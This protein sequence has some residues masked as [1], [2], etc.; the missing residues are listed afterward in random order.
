MIYYL[1]EDSLDPNPTG[2]SVIDPGPEGFVHCCDERQIHEVLKAYFP[3]DARVLAVVVDP[4]R[5]SSET[6]YEPGSGGEAERFAHVYGP[7]QRSAVVE[8]IA[9]K[10]DG[11]N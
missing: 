7:I 1:A 6:R 10:A 3:S 9:L 5:L 4:T 2:D 11:V 8:V